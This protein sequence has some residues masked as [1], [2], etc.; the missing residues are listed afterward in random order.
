MY[1]YKGA[2]NADQYSIFQKIDID[3]I[4]SI[5]NYYIKCYTKYGFYIKGEGE[6]IFSDGQKI[7]FLNMAFLDKL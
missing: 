3:I 6:K 4:V 5:W 1:G 7:E 2:K